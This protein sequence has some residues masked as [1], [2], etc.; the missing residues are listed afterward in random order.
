MIATAT[1]DRVR[2]LLREG[3][4][5]QR[6]IAR[7]V[8]ISRGTVNAIALGR[9]PDR[10]PRQPEDDAGFAPPSGAHVRCAGCGGL[11]QMPCLACYIR[12]RGRSK[13][14]A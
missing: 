7:H 12:Q 11:V 6:R 14:A 2:Q 1:I 9:R 13:P 10:A 4:L 3:R 8:G 5:S